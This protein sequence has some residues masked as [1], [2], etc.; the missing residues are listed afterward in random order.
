MAMEHTYALIAREATATST[1][2][3]GR[4]IL[5]MEKVASAII[6]M[7][8]STLVTGSRISVMGRE[9]TFI[10]TMKRGILVG[11]ATI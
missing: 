10:N 11:G 1:K 6:T 5:V 3:T 7:M 2:D 8:A 9:S 4:R